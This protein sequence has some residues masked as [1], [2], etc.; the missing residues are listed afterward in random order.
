[1]NPTS[2]ADPGSHGSHGALHTAGA[3]GG[4]GGREDCLDVIV[5]GAGQAGLALAW[6]LAQQ[7]RRFLVLDVAP[8]LGHTWRSRWDS[9]RLFTPAQYDSLPS[10]EFPAPA[11]TY[12]TKD[13]VAD[14]LAAY[15][16]RFELPILLGTTV[17]RLERRADRFA[18]HTN[19]GTLR[20]RQVVVATGPFQNPAIPP[21]ADGLDSGVVQLHSAEY[22]NP[23]QLPP[24]PVIVVGAGN[25]GLQIA[26]ELADHHD[27]TLAVGAHSTELPQR[28]LG[29]DLFWWLT[30]LKVITK[31]ADSRLAKRMR[32]RGDL[33]IGSSTKA[34]R[35]RGVTISPRVVSTSPEGVEFA[36]RTVVQPATVIWA[37]G[38]RSDYSWIE[39]PG[40]ITADGQV[41][42]QRGIT[43]APG[44][45][46]LGLPWQHTRGSALLGFVKHD[47]AWLA[48][49]MHSQWAVSGA[50]EQ[51]QPQ[52]QP[53][54]ARF[55]G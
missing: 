34:L 14:Y 7:N 55:D 9:L 4:N 52:P 27:V 39:A 31:T 2:H 25:S 23:G 1:M 21:V 42:H 11:D 45:F 20:A 29:R 15:S 24:G 8:E 48:D 22:R 44:L 28:I 40:V 49:Q 17:T 47:A 13:Q 3:A 16:A 10:M 12:P 46:F 53:M 38:F 36:D 35:R 30:K 37:T 51:P 54:T 32:A 41:V 18:V 6:H 50:A 43:Q 26:D 19:Q 5:I 33:V